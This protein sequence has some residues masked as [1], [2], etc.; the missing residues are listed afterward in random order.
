MLEALGAKVLSGIVAFSLLMFS[1]FE[2]N[3][4]RFEPLKIAKNDSYLFISSKLVS[5]FDNDFPS[6]FSSGTPI[7][8][9][10]TISIRKG[11]RILG[12]SRFTHTVTFDTAKGVYQ[13]DKGMGGTA[14]LTK[15]MEEIIQEVSH[16]SVSVPY[17]K[18]WGD[19]SIRIEAKL[20]KLRFN[21]TDKDVDLMVLWKY[22]KP[23]AKSTVN[24][25]KA[26]HRG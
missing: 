13:L 11:S 17:R 10:F 15:S 5:A 21:K 2:G 1:S 6:I 20:P 22:K 3:D 26:Q 14:L 9:H 23:S 25:H 7:P 18:N 4:P 24:L 16:F 8:I 12:Q 19:V